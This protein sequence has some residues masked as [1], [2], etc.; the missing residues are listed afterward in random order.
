MRVQIHL[1][2]GQ[3]FTYDGN[4]ASTLKEVFT[5]VTTHL[6]ILEPAYFGLSMVVDGER[7]FLPLKILLF[8]LMLPNGSLPELYLEIEFILD[9][10]SVIKHRNTR[11]WYFMQ[12]TKYF[13]NGQVDVP[14]DK[15]LMLAVWHM[16]AQLGNYDPAKHL[17][18]D[19]FVLEDFLPASAISLGQSRQALQSALA[20]KH[21]KLFS[22]TQDK[23]EEEY[24][25]AT[26][27]RITEIP[28]AV[29]IV[30][31]LI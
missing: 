13:L 11:H 21:Q 6:Q 1:P 5:A 29:V 20:T 15:A 12:I 28:I 18:V 25:K 2:N 24:L 27:V 10:V 7:E 23:A 16:Q 19:Y 31:F 8:S 3:P 26:Q 14:L 9:N 17:G 4:S 30:F 22:L